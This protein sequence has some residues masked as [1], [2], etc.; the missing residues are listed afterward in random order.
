M[1]LVLDTDVVVAAMR[2][3][4]GASAALLRKALESKVTLL[5]NVALMLEYEAVCARPEHLEAAELTA[6]QLEWFLDGLATL[7]EPVESRFIWRPTLRDPEDEMILEAAVNGRATA[8]VT[9]NSRDFG[10]A[11]GRFGVEVLLPR[12]ALRKL[13]P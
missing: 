4:T 7:I 13:K 3:P 2:S 8:I 5:A 10:L 12:E 11:P 9:F 1:R 6:A